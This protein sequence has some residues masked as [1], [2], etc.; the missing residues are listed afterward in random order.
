MS[1]DEYK[2]RFYATK[3]GIDIATNNTYLI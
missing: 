1:L 2:F 3:I